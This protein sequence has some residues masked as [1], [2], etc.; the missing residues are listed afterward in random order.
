M[1]LN[2]EPQ[3]WFTV[4][5]GTTRRP[6]SKNYLSRNVWRRPSGLARQPRSIIN[7]VRTVTPTAQA[8]WATITPRSA[9][10]REAKLPPKAAPIGVRTDA[11]R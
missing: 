2:P 6:R 7:L 11:V 9:A 3:A 10:L 8:L 5:A 4:N 1:A